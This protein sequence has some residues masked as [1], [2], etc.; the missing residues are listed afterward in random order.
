MA[1]KINLLSDAVANQIAAGEVI[2]RPASVIKEL[3]ENAIDAGSSEINVL[4]KDAGKTFIQVIDNGCGMSETDAR[5]CFERHAT[6]KIKSAEDLFAIH[7]MGF[8]GEAMASI[9]AIAQIT[10]KTKP[11]EEELG[12][13]IKISGSQID[14]QQAVSCPPGTNIMV[15]SLFYNVP[16]RRKFLKT[17]TTEL[18]HII[19]EFQHVALAHPEIQFKLIHNDSEIYNLPATNRKQRII[20]IFGKSIMQNLL[21][22]SSQTSIVSIKGFVGKPEKAKKSF[23]EQFFFVNNRYMRHPYFHKAIMS[24]Y[25][26]LLAPETIPSYFIFFEIAP[27]SIDINIHPTKTEIKFEEE[28]SIFQILTVS[29]K[30]ALGKLN[31]MPSIDFNRETAFDIPVNTN[32]ENVKIPQVQVNPTYNPFKDKPGSPYKSGEKKH[33]QPDWEKLYDGYKDADQHPDSFTKDHSKPLFEETQTDSFQDII[34]LKNKFIVTPVKSGLMLIDQ[35][36]AHQRILFEKFVQNLALNEIAAQ[37]QLYPETMELES[38]DHIL[39]MEYLN[40]L[41][42][43]GFDINDIG[44]QS[45]IINGCPAFL[46]NPK[47]VQL[48]E[49][50]IQE[51]KSSDGQKKLSPKERLANALSGVAAIPYG[52][53]LSNK[54]MNEIIDTLF[55]CENPNYTPSGKKI[56]EILPLENIE[57]MLK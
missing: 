33:R 3:L 20:H 52:K 23:G 2:Q 22:I 26:K 56:L 13:E 8:R 37:Q 44:N 35:R 50:F 32:P 17:D 15:K 34:Q 45:I 36:R 30:E 1:D 49:S 41:H 27:E 14:S 16:A 53:K 6:S 11:V 31:V 24:A 18:R 39:L 54:E 42:I 10:L 9:G 48:L 38:S 40:D 57:S 47:P 28:K 4:V 12:T 29:T 5:M 43:L 7:T 55:A 21:D 19:N 46:Y 51:I 25:D